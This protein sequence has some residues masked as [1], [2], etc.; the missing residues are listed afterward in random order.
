[1]STRTVTI[2]RETYTVTEP[3][4]FQ[5][6]PHERYTN[7][8]L[9]TDVDRLD[10]LVYLFRDVKHAGWPNT[11]LAVDMDPRTATSFGGYLHRHL[12]ERFSEADAPVR[13]WVS[14]HPEDDEDHKIPD[15]V[16]VAITQTETW[17]RNPHFASLPWKQSPGWFLHVHPEWWER[18]QYIFYRNIQVESHYE[19]IFAYDNL[20]HLVMIVKNAGKGFGRILEK[21]IPFI[22]RWTILDTGSTD[23][24]QEVIRSVLGTRVRGQL[25]E[26][27]FVDFGTSRNRA[28]ELAGDVCKFTVMLDDTYYFTGDIRDFLNEV[29]SDQFADS[30]S[31][32][33]NSA[34]VQYASNRLIKSQRKLR[35]KFKIHEVID[36]RDNVTVI[37]PPERAQIHDEQ[38][39]YMQERTTKR[40][41][42]DLRLLRES[43]QEE[44]ENPRHWYYMAQTYVGMQDY[45]HAYR[46][47]LARVFH[48][49]EGFLQEKIDACF[50][51]ARCAQF[52]L[53]R[54]WEEVRPLYERAYAMDP[55][56]PDSVYFLAIKDLM[57]QNRRSAYEGFKKAFRIGYPL[58]AQYSLKPTL[59]FHFTPKFL[60]EL[61][62]EFQDYKTGQAATTLYTQHNPPDAMIN[63]WHAIYQQMVRW[64]DA[65]PSSSSELMRSSKPRIAFV[66]DGN[67]TPWTGADILVKGLG[68]S[69]TYIVEMARWI[70]RS[71]EYDVIVFCRSSSPEQP[72]WYENVEY[73][74][75]DELYAYVHTHALHSVVISRFSEYLP[76]MLHSPAVNNVFLVVHDL[77]VSGLHIHLNPP[78]LRQIF[79]LT[80]WHRTHFT[81]AF[82]TLQPLTS[83]MHYG[84]DFPETAVGPA[85]PTQWTRFIYSSF[86]NRGLSVLLE[87]WPAIL[88]RLPDATLDLFVDLDHAWTNQHYPDM[89]RDIRQRL[90]DLESTRSIRVRGWV[91]KTELYKAWKSAHIWLYPCIF[92]E[93][94]CLTAL[95]AA[96]SN[97]LVIAADLAALQ[98]TVGDRGYL[99]AGD[100]LTKEWQE[101]ALKQLDYCL[102][103]PEAAHVR[104][105][106]N[107]EWARQHTWQNQAEQM[108]RWFRKFPLEHCQ[109]YTLV[110]ASGHPSA[111]RLLC[112][113]DTPGL[114]VLHELYERNGSL[115]AEV[116]HTCLTTRDAFRR[117]VHTMSLESCVREVGM[118]E[119]EPC[120]FQYD[121]V[122]YDSLAEPSAFQLERLWNQ[123]DS[124]S[125]RLV[126]RAERSQPQLQAFL[127]EHALAYT[128]I[129]QTDSACILEKRVQCVH[130]VLY[131]PGEFYTPMYNITRAYYR[132][133]PTVKT[134][135]YAFSETL[136][137]AVEEHDDLLWIR[138][139]ERY[140]VWQPLNTPGLFEKTMIALDWV[141][142]RYPY[143]YVVRSNISTV[144]NFDRLLPRLAHQSFGYGG[145]ATLA[146]HP[147]GEFIR[148][149]CILL[150][151]ELVGQ[152]LAHRH[153]MKAEL[154]D[155]I[156]LSVLIQQCAPQAFP[157]SFTFP[158]QLCFVPNCQGDDQ[159]LRKQIRLEMDLCFRF[160]HM[161]L[162]G[163]FNQNENAQR[164]IDVQQ[165]TH[166]VRWLTDA[167]DA[168]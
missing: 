20:L 100:P 133:F 141:H 64:E 21:N 82:P 90:R 95:E 92:R 94:F 44:P 123:V 102:R 86:A 46:Y 23:G 43:I 34:D 48:P 142:Q 40:K 69:E 22:D 125:G 152:L 130:L 18:F 16:R 78:K 108:L 67:W 1:M 165:M 10:R 131:S 68:G 51:A 72:V 106:R 39:D 127:R 30:F 24:T 157:P 57:D 52:Q 104:I 15:S 128:R 73:R 164:I 58:H 84:L 62:Y 114:S 115:E 19:M 144:I 151:H 136:R 66:A 6:I 119:S 70:Q 126:C 65:R 97:T 139:T 76:V 88:Q 9:F 96:A 143:A 166:V 85:C 145:A 109:D 129:L 105:R 26:E 93:T 111:Q 91:T 4:E 42:L 75:L 14:L 112:V 59:S 138:G 61:C 38:N 35:Y 149:I 41:A 13:F 124:R 99:I 89:M 110:P 11:P 87:M 71:G 5:P 167:L 83:A 154:A 50:E 163:Q 8:K 77:S 116:V 54:P 148:G 47:F 150:S 159:R 74:D 63:S 27:P 33:I 147:H 28:L 118:R 140:D 168:A 81:E 135:Y 36:E 3:H 29:R 17:S 120:K 45:E 37:I 161:D 53:K 31:L 80:E 146:F 32:Y 113:Q 162:Q 156:G 117:N 56:R 12:V 49:E 60:A 158:D 137:T 98:D 101:Q 103:Y 122:R 132:R 7:L 2:D 153:L 134:L 155:D 79:T 55:T 160:K 107:R 121:I 25:Y